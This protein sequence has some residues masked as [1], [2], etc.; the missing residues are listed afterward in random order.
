MEQALQ[1][2]GLDRLYEQWQQ[3]QRFP[4][5]QLQWQSGI[6]SGIGSLMGNRHGTD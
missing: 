6:T 3:A 1:Q 4:Y 5:E 2:G